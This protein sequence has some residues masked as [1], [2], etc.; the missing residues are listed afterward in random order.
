MENS[1]RSSHLKDQ[2]QGRSIQAFAADQLTCQTVQQTTVLAQDRGRP[3]ERL[4]KDRA[5]FFVDDLANTLGVVAL[6]TDLTAEK[7]HLVFA[8]ERDWPEALAHAEVGDHA[9]DD[10]RGTLDVVA[11]AGAHLAEDDRFSRVSAE[12]GDDRVAKLAAAHI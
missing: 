11:R 7:D 3:R 1:A 12:R 4:L 5:D 6:L 2:F 10:R 9:A 8:T